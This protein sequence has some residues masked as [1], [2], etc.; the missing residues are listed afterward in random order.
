M[1][2]YLLRHGEAE[3][4]AP[5]GDSARPL[6]TEGTVRLER[7]APGWR[8]IVADVDRILASP[9]LR[10]QQ[11]AAIFRQ[12]VAAAAPL[13]TEPALTPDARPSDALVLL[14]HWHGKGCRGVACVGHEPHLG[15]L[16]ALLLMG[17]ERNAIPFKKGMLVAV[18]IEHRAAMLGRLLVAV[19]QRIAGRIGT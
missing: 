16:L 19:S 5:G 4:S 8:R 2:V 15:H 17:S 3:D 13:D 18:E 11:T 9:L 6:S 12:A 7:A 14:Q 1:I 10:A